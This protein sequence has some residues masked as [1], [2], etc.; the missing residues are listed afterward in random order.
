MKSLSFIIKASI[1]GLFIAAAILLWMWP[2]GKT[3]HQDQTPLLPSAPSLH[4][5]PVPQ[6]G[7]WPES[8]LFSYAGAVDQASPSVVNIYTARKVRETVNPLFERFFSLNTPARSRIQT[9]LGSGVIF[10]GNGYII[11]NFHVVKNA[12]D[13][14]VSLY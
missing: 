11:T 1:A 5:E 14:R 13:I 4:P 10:T 9:G 12:D 7:I 2:S 8:G 3:G 6:A